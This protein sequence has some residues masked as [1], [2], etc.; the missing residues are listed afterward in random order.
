ML[1]LGLAAAAAAER[2]FQGPAMVE[3][4]LP[5]A[6]AVELGTAVDAEVEPPCPRAPRRAGCNGAEGLTE[7]GG[8]P[9]DG[10]AFRLG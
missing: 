1:V 6:E 3:S 8:H 10:G 7:L 9:P 2:R 4:S 5:A